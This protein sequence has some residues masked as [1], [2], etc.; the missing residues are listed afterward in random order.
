MLGNVATQHSFLIKAFSLQPTVERAARYIS[1]CFHFFTFIFT[2]SQV[3]SVTLVF[4]REAEF[5][6]YFIVM[7]CSFLKSPL[8]VGLM[9]VSQAKQF[10]SLT[11]AFILTKQNSTKPWGMAR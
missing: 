7:H 10:R 3:P 5:K 9:I 6:Q 8:T 4:N 2:K 11:F 1:R